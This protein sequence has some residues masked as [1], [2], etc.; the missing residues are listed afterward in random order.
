MQ[1][2]EGKLLNVGDFEDAKLP[3]RER[4]SEAQALPTLVPEPP[5]P[6]GEHTSAKEGTVC[7]EIILSSFVKQEHFQAT[8]P[9]RSAIYGAHIARTLQGQPSQVEVQ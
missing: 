6:T 3:A 9:K 8:K 2:V 7:L 5:A 4:V 1:Y